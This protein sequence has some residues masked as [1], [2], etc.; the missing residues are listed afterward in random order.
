LILDPFWGATKRGLDLLISIL[1]LVILT[2]ILLIIIIIIRLDSEGPALYWQ[3][4]VG[5]GGR[6]FKMVKFRTMYLDA[7]EN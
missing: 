2:P 5:K 6:I 3:E 7:E 1:V 4:R